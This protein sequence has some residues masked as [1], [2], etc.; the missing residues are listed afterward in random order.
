MGK[1]ALV[2][3][4]GSVREVCVQILEGLG[5][6]THLA[7]SASRGLAVLEGGQM[8]SQLSYRHSVI[9]LL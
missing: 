2:I 8:L 1:S 6:E 4:A 3:D 5:F 9:L 7:G